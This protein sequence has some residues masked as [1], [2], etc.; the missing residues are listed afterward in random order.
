MILP[1]SLH[2]N[3]ARR[4]VKQASTAKAFDLTLLRDIEAVVK[5]FKEQV[6]E[7]Q[8]RKEPRSRTLGKNPS[9]PEEAISAMHSMLLKDFLAFIKPFNS[10]LTHNHQNNFYMEREW[11]K[12]GNMKFETGQVSRIVVAMG[13]KEQSIKDFPAYEDRIFEL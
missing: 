3:E 5:G 10:E 2:P 4:K 11:R 8:E 1:G 12:Y 7:R 9:S 6:I 13:Y